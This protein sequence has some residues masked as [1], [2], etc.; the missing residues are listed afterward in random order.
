VKFQI[1]PELYT[2]Y[3][4]ESFKPHDFYFPK[5]LWTPKLNLAEIIEK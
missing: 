1:S 3:N 2:P 4:I 5:A